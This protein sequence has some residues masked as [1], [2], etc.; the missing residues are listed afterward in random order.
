MKCLLCFSDEIELLVRNGMA[1]S[2]G[3]LHRLRGRL[4]SLPS[5]VPLDYWPNEL[6]NSI[7]AAAGFQLQQSNEPSR[8]RATFRTWFFLRGVVWSQDKGGPLKL[9]HNGEIQQVAHFRI[10]ISHAPDELVPEQ[11]PSWLPT[12][13]LWTDAEESPETSPRNLAGAQV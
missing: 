13:D 5:Q 3:C 10:K 8:P 2:G 7:A 9:G 12:H 1:L 4:H 11:P 6:Q